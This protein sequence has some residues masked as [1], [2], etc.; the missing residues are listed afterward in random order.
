MLSGYNGWLYMLVT[1]AGWL[2]VLDGW[3][4]CLC[5]WLTTL[6]GY[7][8]YSACTLWHAM[9]YFHLDIMDLLSMLPERSG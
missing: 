7:P 6:A 3:I 4:S 1:L 8:G 5:N 9:F 2:S